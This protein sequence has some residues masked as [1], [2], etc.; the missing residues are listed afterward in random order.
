VLT[1]LWGGGRA[2]CGV[3]DV[4]RGDAGCVY[5]GGC[6]SPTEN[7]ALVRPTRVSTLHT[8]P[9]STRRCDLACS[10]LSLPL[11]GSYS[12]SGHGGEREVKR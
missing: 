12:L 10:A 2:Q 3:H 5:A 7:L 8:S 11:R 9:A 6:P 1:L 4:Q